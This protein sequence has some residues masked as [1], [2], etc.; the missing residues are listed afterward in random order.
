MTPA[1]DRVVGYLIEAIMRHGPDSFP[2]AMLFAEFL[3][4][5]IPPSGGAGIETG[6]GMGIAQ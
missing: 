3:P 2:L 6:T 1:A 5:R 4:R